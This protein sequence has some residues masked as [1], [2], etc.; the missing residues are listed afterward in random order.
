MSVGVI[1]AHPP[2]K[3]EL[4]QNS[5]IASKLLKATKI[6]FELNK[7]GFFIIFYICAQQK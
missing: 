7:I 3:K 6:A 5:H 4:T 1:K 2:M